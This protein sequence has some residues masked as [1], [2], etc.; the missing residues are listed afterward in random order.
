MAEERV[1]VEREGIRLDQFLKLSAVALSGGEAK[2]L[3]NDGLVKVDG[4]KETRRG[5]KLAYGHRVEISGLKTEY[6]VVPID[7]VD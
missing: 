5:R 4:E 7:K 2:K 3:I 1:Q 6:R